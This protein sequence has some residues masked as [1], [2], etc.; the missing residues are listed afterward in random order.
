[1]GNDKN[2]QIHSLKDFF[3]GKIDFQTSESD[4]EINDKFRDSEVYT[5]E[6]SRTKYYSEFLTTIKDDIMKRS[7]LKS[8]LK[9]K[10]FYFVMICFSVLIITPIF[11]LLFYNFFK[12][13]DRNFYVFVLSSLT[14][15]IVAIIVLPKIIAEYLF[16]K[17]EDRN[18]F[19]L[20]DRIINAIREEND[21]R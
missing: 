19:N 5:S 12:M 6:V 9:S 16:D 1:M 8:S 18:T 20:V 13:D 21:K 4:K 3:D 14:E 15:I 10:F 17:E 11:T 2:Q 7:E